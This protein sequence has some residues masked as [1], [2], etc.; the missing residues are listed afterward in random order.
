M[1]EKRGKLLDERDELAKEFERETV[2]WLS[3]KPDTPEAR[4]VVT[5]REE[6][7]AQLRLSYWKLDPFIRARTYYHRVGVM[8]DNGQADFKAAGLGG[9]KVGGP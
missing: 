9:I 2:Q 4:A 3:M 7:N 1:D 6:L 5:R 8:K